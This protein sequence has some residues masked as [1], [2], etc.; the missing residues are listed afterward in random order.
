MD[1]F[2]IKDNINNKYFTNDLLFYKNYKQPIPKWS[3]DIKAA[4]LFC[5]FCD[6]LNAIKKYHFTDIE[7]IKNPFDDNCEIIP[8]NIDNFN[9][10]KQILIKKIEKSKKNKEL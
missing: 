3:Y 4:Y 6:V 5:D 10:K 2:I 8:F 1:K 9:E 7:I